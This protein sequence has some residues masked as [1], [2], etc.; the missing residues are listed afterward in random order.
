MRVLVLGGDGYLGWPTAMNLT[1]AGHEVAVADNYLRR[2]LCREENVE[3]LYL[4]PNLHERV[5]LWK[6]K[7]GHSIRLFVGDLNDW[8]FV[9]H[10]F[11]SFSPEGIVH[12]AEQPA[13]PYSMLN[14]KAAMLTLQNNLS[15][16]ANTIFDVSDYMTLPHHRLYSAVHALIIAQVRPKSSGLSTFHQRCRVHI[17]HPQ[18]NYEDEQAP[19]PG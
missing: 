10:V 2:R 17:N 6:T 3:P 16:T 14:R 5:E 7:S 4:V 18:H 13:A 1:V 15:V 12:Y 11:Q 9:K 8:D 19:I